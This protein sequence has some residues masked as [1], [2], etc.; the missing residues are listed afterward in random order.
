MS[1]T[2]AAAHR[3]C[4]ASDL[5]SICPDMNWQGYRCAQR[6][7]CL[8]LHVQAIST[9]ALDPGTGTGIELPLQYLSLAEPGNI[10]SETTAT[11]NIKRSGGIPQERP[12]FS[13]LIASTTKLRKA[14]TPG[15]INRCPAGLRRCLDQPKKRLAQ[16]ALG[17]CV[18]GMGLKSC[19]ARFTQ[20][21][22]MGMWP[23]MVRRWYILLGSRNPFIWAGMDMM[24][25]N[26]S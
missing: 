20:F 6:W 23:T 18:D 21:Q 22:E 4:S 11:F 17:I 3:C 12:L 10:W 9:S 26:D 25:T 14:P 16:Q 5:I 8:R 24:T 7:S 19:C 13:G 15:R 2:F 1:D